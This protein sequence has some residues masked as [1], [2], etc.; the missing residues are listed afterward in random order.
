MVNLATVRTGFFG[1]F[2]AA[3]SSAG[4]GRF[5]RLAAMAV[6]AAIA[7]TAFSPAAAGPVISWVPPYSVEACKNMV[8]RDFGGGIGMKDGLT[9]L[10][11]QWWV[12]DGPD[13]KQWGDVA[14]PGFDDDVRYF[15][16]W[17][18]A[19]GVKVTLCVVN[20]VGDWNWGEARRSF[21][22][23]RPAFVQS[24][25]GEVQRLG[26]DGVELDLEGPTTP[27]VNDSVQYINLVRDLGAALHPLGKTVTVASYAAQYNAP[28]W[29]WWPELMKTAAAV[30]S[31]G[32]DDAG[33]NSPAGYKY[34]EQK[35]RANPAYKLMIGM[36]GGSGSWQGNT[37]AQNID[38]VLNDGQMGIG[39]W[40]AALGDGT[41]E[42]AATW[43]KL[44]TIRSNTPSEIANP[45]LK[46]EA[47]LT[48]GFTLRRFP[49]GLF[50]DLTL[51]SRSDVRV[52]ILD[53]Q[54]A[55]VAELY[56]GTPEQGKLSVQWS[57]RNAKGSLSAPGSYLI[58][59]TVDGKTEAKA[60]SL[61]PLS[62]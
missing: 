40:D 60:F 17:G 42:S 48:R 1:V 50:A 27:S 22:D 38:Y 43:Q 15:R 23:N 45:R 44:H 26:L 16:D 21:V 32:Y 57:G 29:K 9:F 28:N 30:T 10:A 58:A 41:W 13:I 6:M 35:K 12:T 49:D 3:A 2:P 34:P 19:N 62:P 46:A 4:A 61:A 55:Q 39:I 52:S 11:L 18:K 56:R 31:M 51:P 25:V 7:A 24:L 59:A 5:G 54:G 47:A 37:A 53:L 36:F 14:G 33:I 20:H 8:K